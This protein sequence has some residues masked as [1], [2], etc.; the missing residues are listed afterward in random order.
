MDIFF[1]IGI[2]ILVGFVGGRLSHKI[3]FPSVVGYLIAGL[4]LGPSFLNFLHPQVLDKLVVFNDLALSIIAFIIGSE[5]NLSNLKKLG[6]G[7]ITIIFSESFS[8]FF[9]VTLGVYLLTKKLYLALILGAIAPASAPAGTAV[10][11]QEYKAKGPLTQALY[12]VVGFDDGLGII[13][14]AFACTI[15]KLIMG[16]SPQVM[17]EAIKGPILE[18]T[19]SLVLGAGLGFLLGFFVRRLRRREDILALSLATIFILTGIS[20]FFH[21]SL[22]LSNLTLG[23]IFANFFLFANRRV[24][25]VLSSIASP[26]YI[27]FFVMAGAHLNIKL[28]PA[29]GILGLVY[30]L[31]RTVGLVGG[32]SLGATISKS[33]HVVRKYLGWGILSQAGVAIGL[34]MLVV[35]EF[36]SLGI[37]GKNLALT[38]INTIAATTIVFEILGPIGVKYAITKAGEIRNLK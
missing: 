5:L 17:E 19:G 28:L 10:V 29:M 18:I 7:I 38:V 12:A 35:T 34:A 2:A 26:I 4:I 33:P 11:L 15:A 20:K 21:F 22:I 16:K 1:F 31:C 24:Q 27:I 14:F 8:A 3:K 25:E 9:L 36:P 13:I 23:M 30:I 6:K 32:A 37:E